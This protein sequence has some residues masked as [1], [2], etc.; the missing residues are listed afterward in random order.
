VSIVVNAVRD[1]CLGLPAG[2]DVAKALIAI[3]II[4]ALFVP[5]CVNRYRRAV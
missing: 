5:L 3:G 4:L 1:L 2:D